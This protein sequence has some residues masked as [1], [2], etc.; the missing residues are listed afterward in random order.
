SNPDYRQMIDFLLIDKLKAPTYACH[1]M[2]QDLRII[3]GR[4]DEISVGGFGQAMREQ[5]IDAAIAAL[6]AGKPVVIS[7]RHTSRSDDGHSF[8]VV[9]DEDGVVD[10]LEGW[11]SNRPTD[12]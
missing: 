11:A 9:L 7:L 5:A 2:A 12:I 1:E 10:T 4:D 3:A 8:S 6:E